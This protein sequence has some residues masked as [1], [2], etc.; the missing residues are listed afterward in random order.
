MATGASPEDARRVR[1]EHHEIPRQGA[2]LIIPEAKM[3][4]R[5]HESPGSRTEEDS[6]GVRTE[7]G[8]HVRRTRSPRNPITSRNVVFP[9]AFGPTSAWKRSSFRSVDRRQRNRSAWTRV[10]VKSC[11]QS[12]T[13]DEADRDRCEG[14]GAMQRHAAKRPRRHFLVTVGCGGSPRVASGRRGPFP[15]ARSNPAHGRALAYASSPAL[16]FARSLFATKCVS[17]GVPSKSAASRRQ[18]VR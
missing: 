3:Q 14:R 4:R 2:R 10:N 18:F 17:T 16:P 13:G 7:G 11:Y 12:R 15:P 5:R 8:K 6:F 1:D 9:L